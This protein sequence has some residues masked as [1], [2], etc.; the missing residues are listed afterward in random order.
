MLRTMELAGPRGSATGEVTAYCATSFE[1]S[2][3]A[4]ISRPSSIFIKAG[5]RRTGE[6]AW[7]VLYPST[8]NAATSSSRHFRGPCVASVGPP[9]GGREEP[10]RSL[11]RGRGEIAVIAEPVLRTEPT[12][13][14]AG[15]ASRRAETAAGPHNRRVL[16]RAAAAGTR[17]AERFGRRLRAQGRGETDRDRSQRRAEGSGAQ[18][19]VRN[20]AGSPRAALDGAGRWR[21]AS[22]RPRR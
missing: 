16:R 15:T 11:T 7:A 21:A 13:L 14:A 4:P 19:Q 6:A 2:R 20:G 8:P 3:E 5:S 12:G 17:S 1:A 18:R 10:L 22:C 9:G